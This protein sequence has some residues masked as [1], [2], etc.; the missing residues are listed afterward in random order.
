MRCFIQLARSFFTIEDVGE[1][2]SIVGRMVSDG[3]SSILSSVFITNGD[4]DFALGF[5]CVSSLYVAIGVG[6]SK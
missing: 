5:G 3:E 2:G 4:V 1:S 6:T